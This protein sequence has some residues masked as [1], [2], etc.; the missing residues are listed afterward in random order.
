[1]LGNARQLRLARAALAQQQLQRLAQAARLAARR[2][3][4]GLELHH[5]ALNC[6]CL[7]RRRTP[8]LAQ[9]LQRAARL[10]C[11]AAQSLQ[12]TRR[13]TRLALVLFA[14]SRGGLILRGELR[15]ASLLRLQL[16]RRLL[17]R[18]LQL[19][20]P[21]AQGRLARLQLCKLRLLCVHLSAQRAELRRRRGRRLLCARLRGAA[22]RKLVVGSAHLRCESLA[23]GREAQPLALRGRR[24]RRHRLLLQR[25]ALLAHARAILHFATR[26]RKGRALLGETRALRMQR[27]CLGSRGRA[28]TCR[29]LSRTLDLLLLSR[30]VVELP[31]RH[32]LAPQQR[33]VE[34]RLR[35]RLVAPRR[36][37]GTRGR[38]APL[39][40]ASKPLSRL[41][42][43]LDCL[44]S[45]LQRRALFREARLLRRDR[46]AS[47]CKLAR[48]GA[49]RRAQRLLC[50]AQAVQPA[51]QRLLLRSERALALRQR[52]LA[53]FEGARGGSALLG[54]ARA[55][56]LK[57]AG[58]NAASTLRVA[59][60]SLRLLG[61]MTAHLGT[62]ALAGARGLLLLQLRSRQHVLCGALASLC[63]SLRF[64]ELAS[65][66]RHRFALAVELCAR[67]A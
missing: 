43:G 10:L 27:L 44:F 22:L 21:L 7:L 42:R 64:G 63:S 13:G 2:V 20:Q 52:R 30:H 57:S 36:S 38:L 14:L 54:Q 41:L 50:L 67:D 26:H 48:V 49:L 62:L 16:G 18:R 58:E 24:R 9:P 61:Q 4:I 29:L 17:L 34:L 59:L 39:R 25:E 23:L 32:R 45:P 28:R 55:L 37:Q 5:G 6:C 35:L 31:S 19:P 15:C 33:R 56:R 51:L 8:F 47:L 46:V 66:L 60:A 65:L 12:R 11:F 1:M 3:A 53:L 40:L